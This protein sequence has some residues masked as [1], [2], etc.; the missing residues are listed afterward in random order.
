MPDDAPGQAVAPYDSSRE[1]AAQEDRFS[2][3]IQ[4]VREAMLNPAVDAEKATVMSRLMTD[5]EDRAERRQFNRDLN[6]AIMDMPVITKDGLIVIKKDN[7]VIQS[8]R[9]AKFEDIDRVVRPILR[10]HNLAIRFEVGESGGQVSVRPVLT[11]RNGYTEKGEAMRGPID[12][13]G[14]K[15]NVQGAGSTVSYLKRYTMCAALNIITEGVDDDGNQ[16]RAAVVSMPHERE[17]LVLREAEQANEAGGYLA[18]FSGLGPKDRAW[19]IQN[20][21]HERFGGQAALPSG[22]RTEP[23]VRELEREDPPAVD[24][25][26]PPAEQRQTSGTGGGGQKRQLTPEQWA[27]GFKTDVLKCQSVDFLDEFMDGKRD[28]LDRLKAAD[29]ALWD[30]CQKAYRD[31]KAA[32]ED[33]R[34]V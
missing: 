17:Q 20:G 30:E 8:T 29:E 27:A 31:R 4:M 11:H 25:G 33:G 22:H 23:E 5:L 10:Q 21:H 19:L 12:S 18:Y 2:Q 9:F 14:S 6:A 1:L 26:E 34:L 13:S 7:R 28:K 32:I 16:G 3:T 24:Q 15:N